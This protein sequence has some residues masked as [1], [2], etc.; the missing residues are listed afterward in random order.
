MNPLNIL[1]LLLGGI[2][3]H[4]PCLP[5]P[6]LASA[7]VAAGDDPDDI[8]AAVAEW[9]LAN[10]PH[11]GARELPGWLAAARAIRGAG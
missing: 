8:A 10:T 3:S 5:P 4:P 9:L 2:D 11:L 6:A 7:I 1:S